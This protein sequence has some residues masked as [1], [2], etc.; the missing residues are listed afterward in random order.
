MQNSYRYTLKL[1]QNGH[2][3][4][5]LQDSSGSEANLTSVQR[6]YILEVFVASKE[7]IRFCGQEYELPG[8]FGKF[9][10]SRMSF[11]LERRSELEQLIIGLTLTN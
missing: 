11:P 5:A 2:V 7:L 4:L 1:E 10:P 8:I 9:P 3:D 6:K